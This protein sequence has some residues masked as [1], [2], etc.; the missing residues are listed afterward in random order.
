MK[1]PSS[2]ENM[3]KPKLH[4]FLGIKFLVTMKIAFDQSLIEKNANLWIGI[5]VFFSTRIPTQVRP[6]QILLK[7]Q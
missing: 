5:K 2:G 6:R 3:G 4:Q 1:N 7:Y